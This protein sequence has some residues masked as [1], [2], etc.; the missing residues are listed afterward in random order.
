VIGRKEGK[1][2]KGRDMKEGRNMQEGVEGTRRK[3]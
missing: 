1:E 3:E 2:G